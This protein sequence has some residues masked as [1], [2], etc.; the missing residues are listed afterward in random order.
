MLKEDNK[1]ITLV[2]LAVT[3][4]VLLILAGIAIN[5][6]IGNNGLFKRAENAVGTWKKAEVNEKE[7]IN[8]FEKI[9]D[10]TLKD[11]GL[12]GEND[13]SKKFYIKLYDGEVL[14]KN[15]ECYFTDEENI[16]TWCS[17]KN[18]DN[19]DISSSELFPGGLQ[20]WD[21]TIKSEGQLFRLSVTASINGELTDSGDLYDGKV[22]EAYREE[23]R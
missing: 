10:E 3:I 16:M 21:F 19:L 1:G 2:A 13:D 22:F 23:F 15:L 6:T 4:I 8:K 20:I 14:V 5:L 9:Y 12:E 11:L 7:E 18:S 17:G